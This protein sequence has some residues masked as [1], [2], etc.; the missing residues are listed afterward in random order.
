MKMILICVYKDVYE[1]VH[2]M[3]ISLYVE[4]FHMSEMLVDLCDLCAHACGIKVLLSC[5]VSCVNMFI[6]YRVGCCV[7]VF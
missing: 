3:D 1:D 2:C 5:F 7:A 6:I 4:V